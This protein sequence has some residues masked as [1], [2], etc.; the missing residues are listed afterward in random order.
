M[1]SK[2]ENE[3]NANGLGDGFR[4]M[5]DMYVQNLLLMAS[6]IRKNYYDTVNYM[7]NK[8]GVKL[9]EN[10]NRYLQ[11]YIGK[12]ESSGLAF[13]E[14]KADKLRIVDEKPENESHKIWMDPE[15]KRYPL[16]E[17]ETCSHPELARLAHIYEEKLSKMRNSQDKIFTAL[18]N[19]DDVQKSFVLGQQRV[20]QIF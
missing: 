9:F 8:K 19:I 5:M 12:E 4:P 6:N 7:I 18:M 20:M 17:F 10:E 15:I 3:T 11:L 16:E 1:V 14:W 13:F 2:I